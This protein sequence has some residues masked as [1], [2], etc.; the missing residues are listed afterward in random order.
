MGDIFSGEPEY[1]GIVEEIVGRIADRESKDEAELPPIGSTVDCD[2]L[3]CL[4]ES[5]D[6]GEV[7]FHYEGYQVTVTADSEIAIE[8]TN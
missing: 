2:A 3:V 4:I 1:G 5:M 6:S 8:A 7:I